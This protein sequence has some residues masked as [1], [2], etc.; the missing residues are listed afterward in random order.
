MNLFVYGVITC[1]DKDENDYFIVLT[2]LY[3]V[4]YAILYYIIILLL[5]NHKPVITGNSFSSNC[6]V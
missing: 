5:N 2:I 4:H 3:I 1:K 6:I